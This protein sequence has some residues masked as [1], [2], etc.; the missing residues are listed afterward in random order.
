ML[1]SHCGLTTQGSPCVECGED[2]LLDGRFTLIEVL[3]RGA[4]GTTYR[5]IDAEVDRAVAIKEMPLRQAEDAKAREL[6][7]REARVLRQL[8]HPGIPRFYESFFTGRGKNRT[9]C[10]VLEHVP[11]RTVHDNF[12]EQRYQPEQ[13]VE[14]AIELLEILA[15]LHR[16][17]P[18]VVHRDVKPANLMQRPDGGLV[19]I[20]FGSV[21]DVIRSEDGGGST[22][23]GTFGY[24][25]PEQ[26]VGDATPAVDV[27][28]VGVLMAVLLS[29][30][31][32]NQLMSRVGALELQGR[33]VV[34]PVLMRCL[35]RFTAVEPR[36]RPRD[37]AAALRE[38]RQAQVAMLRPAPM[39]QRGATMQDRAVLMGSLVMASLLAMG[40]V[41]T[42]AG[43]LLAARQSVPEP[44]PPPV[45]VAPVV[46][47]QPT[48]PPPA[49]PAPVAQQAPVTDPAPFAPPEGA[50]Q[51]EPGPYPPLGSPS[52]LIQVH[53]F[54]DY[55]C[56][57]CSRIEPSLKQLVADNDDVALYVHDTPLPFH[58]NAFRAH[59]AARCANEQGLFWPMHDLLFERAKELS[60]STPYDVWAQGVGA[61]RETFDA[62]M[63]SD[64]YV[65]DIDRAYEVAKQDHGVR[66]T[67][68]TWI[69]GSFVSGAQPYERL[70]EAVRHER[71]LIMGP[72]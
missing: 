48:P 5:A 13:V 25:A 57:F 62:C 31:E 20:D 17:S 22:V 19:L 42:V 40:A 43:V 60:P 63:R 32:P 47:A 7:E 55:Q 21:R 37:A 61:D 66:G 9:L 36:E 46:A 38:L 34:H 70:A 11:G 30:L 72:E 1:C 68:S 3:G 59:H 4:S 24:M 39:V 67:P 53:V 2:P 26:L 50:R 71:R 41:V 6:V 15:Y 33:V 51:P 56:P 14:L 44:P 10:L 54:T 49:P 69:G 12:A 45:A 52:A 18:P 28:A 35:Q 8:E 23:A 29:R 16:L 58:K 27:Y 65:A 64:R